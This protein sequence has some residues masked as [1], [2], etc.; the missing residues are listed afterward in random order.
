MPDLE[1]IKGHRDQAVKRLGECLLESLRRA[2][3][4]DRADAERE[5]LNIDRRLSKKAT[6]VSVQR[7]EQP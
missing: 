6:L 4:K 3:Q 5:M 2:S 7:G 1:L